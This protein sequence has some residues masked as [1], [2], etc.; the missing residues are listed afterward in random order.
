[1]QL[2][3]SR[4]GVETTVVALLRKPMFGRRKFTKCIALKRQHG[5]LLELGLPSA[6]R[7]W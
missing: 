1:M 5:D 4:D 7:L 3:R 6:K 2:W